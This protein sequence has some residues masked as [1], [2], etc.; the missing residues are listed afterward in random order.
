VIVADYTGEEEQL[1]AIRRWWRENGRAVLLGVVIGVA[2]LGVWRG[3]TWYQTEQG[4]AASQ[5]YLR[6]LEKVGKGEPKAIH[7]AAKRLRDDYGRT[8]YA[9]LGA[10]AAGR[11]A[12][13][14]GE[15]ERATEWLR[16]AVDNGDDA[17]LKYLARAR[18]AR[19]LADRD[20]TERA[21]SLLDKQAPPQYDVLYAE[22]RGDLLR[23][24][25]KRKAAASAY[26]KALDAEVQP[27]DAELL[28][29]KLNMVQ[30]SESG[31]GES[32]SGEGGQS[33]S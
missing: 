15:L 32:Q 21:L 25:G 22:I 20:E 14:A 19:V 5:I 10:L 16:W 2:A 7:D 18:L 6:M 24:Q 12:A 26:Q 23:R 9:V 31:A 4:I 1:E 30:P 27:P 28:E 13:E 17:Q 11:A 33:S 3:W 29:R 8:P